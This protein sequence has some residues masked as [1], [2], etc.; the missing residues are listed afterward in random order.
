MTMYHHQGPSQA[1]PLDTPVPGL[2]SEV[3]QRSASPLSS[4]EDECRDDPNLQRIDAFLADDQF[5]EP[6]DEI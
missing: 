5:D 3:R 2:T 6:S 4:L 1:R